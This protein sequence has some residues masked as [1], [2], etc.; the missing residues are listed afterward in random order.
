[1]KTKNRVTK[2]DVGPNRPKQPTDPGVRVKSVKHKGK[3]TK[4]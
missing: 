3:T 2:L 4:S 1:M